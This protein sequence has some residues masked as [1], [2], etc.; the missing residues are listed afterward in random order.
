MPDVG[1]FSRFSTTNE[2]GMPFRPDAFMYAVCA[3]VPL[4]KA[5]VYPSFAPCLA[6][7]SFTSV[8]LSLASEANPMKV[9][10]WSR[11]LSWRSP[12]CA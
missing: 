9:T 3:S 8:S 4:S 11:Y 7:N 10:P 12:I 6:T 1:D 2:Q 5:N